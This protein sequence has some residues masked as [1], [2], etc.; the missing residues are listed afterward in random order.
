VYL[1]RGYR[2]KFVHVYLFCV[3]MS[4]GVHP[5]QR[6]RY[7]SSCVDMCV[8]MCVRMSTVQVHVLWVGV[9]VSVWAWVCTL[10]WGIGACMCGGHA[11]E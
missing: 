3:S 6:H 9:S 7:V 8:G 2:C 5:G 11:Y 1:G 4:M 10:D